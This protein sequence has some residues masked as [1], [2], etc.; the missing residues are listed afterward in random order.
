MQYIRADLVRFVVG[1]GVTAF[2]IGL[3]SFVVPLPTTYATSQ[4]LHTILALLGVVAAACTRAEIRIDTTSTH[5]FLFVGSL[6]VTIVHVYMGFLTFTRSIPL[7]YSLPLMSMPMSVLFTVFAILILLSAIN[8]N[9]MPA[10]GWALKTGFQQLIFVAVV[11]IVCLTSLLLLSIVPTDQIMIL[12]VYDAISIVGFGAGILATGIFLFKTSPRD[13]YS[14]SMA[15]ASGLV[16]LAL[17]AGLMVSIGFSNLWM[18]IVTSEISALVFIAISTGVNFLI[19]VAVVPQ[20]ARVSAVLLVLFTPISF[21]AAHVLETSMSVTEFVA[22]TTS[23]LIHI[24]AAVTCIVIAYIFYYRSRALASWYGS[25]V[26]FTF[27]VWAMIESCIVVLRFLPLPDGRTE[28]V[29]PYLIG[30]L[31]A[32]GSLVFAVRRLLRSASHDDLANLYSWH[33]P[34]Y[35]VVFLMLVAGELIQ[36][37]L[38]AT[39]PDLHLSPT[40]NILLVIFSA[41]ALFLLT[42]FLMLMGTK[43]GGK[44]NFESVAIALQSVWFVSLAL[45][46]NFVD[47]TTGWW[48]AESL[49]VSP[50]SSVLVVLPLFYVM[51][52]RHADEL[53]ERLHIYSVIAKGEI[54]RCHSR[55]AE[56]LHSLSMNTRL[57]DNEL[58][59]IASSMSYISQADE[60]LSIL[61]RTTE[62]NGVLTVERLE[63]LDVYDSLESAIVSLDSHIPDARRQ[64]HIEIEKGQYAVRATGLLVRLLFNLLSG[65]LSISGPCIRIVVNVDQ[66][67]TLQSALTNIRLRL[68]GPKNE[69]HIRRLRNLIRHY[70][71]GLR[72]HSLEFM[73]ARHLTQLFGGSMRVDIIQKNDLRYVEL[74]LSLQSVASNEF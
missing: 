49:L 32:N 34:G 61:F 12:L 26:L 54:L 27:G 11:C 47:W 33:R 63:S 6:S 14:L 44:I 30:G 45:R 24:G 40:G 13:E 43:S 15:M 36:R 39:I 50:L 67:N 37:N 57:D 71:E 65:L 69:N 25:P 53:M 68:E 3:L 74:T 64:I 51:E 18:V 66:D 58:S 8:R 70:L 1:L 29:V 73:I 62:D 60:L 59:T 20:I 31:V 21:A 7:E 41:S 23:I 55:A 56:Q 52:S 46:A 42:D 48:A 17:L 35:V 38:F 10:D 5:G 2:F 28:S 16:S 9:R 4:A 22:P 72:V 19:R